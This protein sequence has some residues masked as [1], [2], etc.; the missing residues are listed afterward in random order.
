MKRN[1]TA[2]TSSEIEAMCAQYRASR[3]TLSDFLDG[4][5]AF[6]PPAPKE[7]CL[8]SDIREI[9]RPVRKR[10]KNK[11]AAN[12]TTFESARVR[13][14]AANKYRSKL[15]DVE[16]RRLH[17]LWQRGKGSIKDLAATVKPVPVSDK[18]LRRRWDLLNLSMV[19]HNALTK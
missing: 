5:P 2:L 8:T 9:D 3:S 17:K 13:G 7:S 12:R 1:T 14:S 10:P 4:S 19:R 11:Q 6:T 16:A 15:K 18:T